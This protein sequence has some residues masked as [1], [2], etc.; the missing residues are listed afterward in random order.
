MRKRHI[1]VLRVLVCLGSLVTVP[2]MDTEEP[3]NMLSAI[4]TW[5][6]YFHEKNY[7]V[8]EFDAGSEPAP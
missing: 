6:A 3:Q 2:H 1:P 4:G 7:A 8:E 5:G